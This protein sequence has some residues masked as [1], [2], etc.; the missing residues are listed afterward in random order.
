MPEITSVRKLRPK[1]KVEAVT[2]H[3]QHSKTM[4]EI[5]LPDAMVWLGPLE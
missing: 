4:R 2:G 1:G 3:W 5:Q